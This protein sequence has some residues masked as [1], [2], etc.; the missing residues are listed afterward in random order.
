MV[1]ANILFVFDDSGSMDWEVM[2]Q[3]LANS[4]SFASTQPDGTNPPDSVGVTPGEVRHRDNND[5]G[6]ADCAFAKNGQSFNGYIYGVDFPTNTYA[7]GGQ[8]CNIADEQA[9]RFRNA[10]FNPLY[11]DPD[12]TYKPWAGLDAAGH[13]F[14]NM[15]ITAALS[16]PYNPNSPTIDLT[17]EN[18][19]GNGS[20]SDRDHDGIPDGFRYYTWNDDGDEIFEN[21][22]EQ[23]HFIKDQDAATQQNFANWFS[24]Y[25]SREYAAK[26]TYS[27]VLSELS[28]I[29]VGLV[30]LHNNAGANTA[31]DL[32]N[33][34][35]TTGHK[36]TLLQQ[37]YHASS[38]GN[39]PLRSALHRAGKYLAC[40]S[41]NGLF[42]TCPALSA[43][44]GGAC[45][46]NFLIAMTDGFYDSQF[47]SLGNTDGPGSG[48]TPWDGGA[49]ADSYQD[50]LA[51]IAMH[52]YERD[53]HPHLEDHV[54]I[55][56]GVD[57]AKHQ[58]MV[59]YG[60]AFGVSGSLADNPVN[61][62]DP[63]NW[64][65]PQ[66]GNEE[67]IDDLRHAA[68]NG[69]GEF[70]SAE[71]PE[72]L[73]D[74][75]RAA[76][77][78]IEERTSSAASVAL[79]SG[80][81]NAD[82]HLYQARFQTGGWTGQLLALP[83]DEQGEV[84]TVS[85]DARDVLDTQHWDQGRTILTYHEG[86]KAGVA[87]RWNSLSAAMQAFLHVDGND[88]VDH[89]GQARLEFL[90]GRRD[91]EGNGFRVRQHLLGDLVHSDP[92][93]VGKP[94]FPNG[95]GT[96]YDQFRGH[97]QNRQKMI[98]VGGNDGMLHGFSTTN[99]EEKLAYVPRAVFN[100]LRDLTEPRYV[101]RY[102]VDGS[103]TVADA[104]G[105]FGSLRCGGAV[106]CWR[107]ILASGLRSGGQAAFAL[108]VTD[109]AQF[110]ENK[111]DQTV[112]WEFTDQHDADLGYTFGVPSIVKMSGDRWAMVLGNGY[113]NTDPDDYVSSTGHAVLYILF[114]DEGLDGSWQLG[115]DFIKL[116]THVGEVD[117]PNG[118]SSPAAVDLDGDFDIEYIYAGDLRGNLWKFDVRDSTPGN[119]AAPV[120]VFTATADDGTPQPITT[121][122]EAGLHP[123]AGILVYFGTGQYIEPQDHRTVEVPTQ[124]FYGIWDKLETPTTGVHRTHLLAQEVLSE[125]NG[126][127]ITSNYEM[128]WASH[129]G[130]YLNLPTAGERQVTNSIL[131]NGR[132]IFT[133]LIPSTVPCSFGGTSWV[134]EVDAET[135]SRL[136]ESPFDLN[137]DHRFTEDDKVVLLNSSTSDKVAIS[138]MLS[139]EGIVSSPAVL[140]SKTTEFKYSSGS[141]GGIFKLVENPGQGARGRIAWRQFK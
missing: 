128:D 69:R 73:V 16:D 27:E 140:F 100:Q 134:M 35:P 38:Q 26:A 28:G 136:Q 21:G 20:T 131:R 60:V 66:A 10:D 120:K 79:N 77:Q 19:L 89:Q 15:P 7:G 135:G 82:S 111:A 126:Q 9:W 91:Q 114:L 83:L 6:T 102:Y 129:Q 94:A 52:Y 132:I 13:P 130:F 75:L 24:Y 97:Y 125:L 43:A 61:N 109:P 17:R 98:Y 107:S 81:H 113:N 18:S 88:V 40:V 42:S 65:N 1:P 74:A 137:A 116:D 123:E 22:E 96:D 36:R 41:G 133:T 12:R 104:H 85:W 45:Q 32:M 62:T 84:Q 95:L 115:T 25:R 108:D 101:H 51:D 72:D 87:F 39:T 46:Q 90:R 59:T 31:I 30:T 48:D 80:S 86:L 47:N 106:S 99:G 37:L 33:D 103:P 58:H 119:W 117:T 93:F 118:L 127:R 34:D 139:T 122:P 2:T 11:F 76:L 92:V 67:K 44:E 138:G 68:Y 71:Q 112:L 8:N 57:E 64:P 121:R 53:L 23:E 124:T 29:R 5:D 49:Y 54:P 141:T 110:G 78:S 3:D 55:L 50:T 14:Q 63:F 105:N 56:P 70:I 4:G